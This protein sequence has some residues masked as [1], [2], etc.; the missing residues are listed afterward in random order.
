MTDGC[1]RQVEY[2]GVLAGAD[3]VPGAQA[4]VDWLISP[5][6]QTDLPLSMFVFPAREGVPLPDVFT[7]FA[8]TVPEPTSIPSTQVADSLGDWLTEWG[9]VMGR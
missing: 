2:V 6:V 3:N 5:E 9:A 8:A 4:V 7:R 1:Y